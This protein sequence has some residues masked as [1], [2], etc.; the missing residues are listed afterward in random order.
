MLKTLKD[1]RIG[2]GITQKA[3]S[4]LMASKGKGSGY[5]RTVAGLETGRGISIKSIEFYLN[6]LGYDLSIKAV[7]QLNQLNNGEEQ[8]PREFEIDVSSMNGTK[9]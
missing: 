5:P 9:K 1:L 6:C 8:K 3:L 7:E 4:E 2:R